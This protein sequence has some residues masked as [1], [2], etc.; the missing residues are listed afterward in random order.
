MTDGSAGRISFRQTDGAGGRGTEDG[1]ADQDADR[2]RSAGTAEVHDPEPVEHRRAAA[3]ED[4]DSERGLRGL[5]GSG[6]SQVGVAAALRAR[7]AARPT[8]RHLAEAETHLN[9]V[10][11]NWVPREE[12]PRSGR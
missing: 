6:S 8:D 4:R 11:R 3:F 9:L 5:V 7:D 12:L 1:A 10:R 2:E